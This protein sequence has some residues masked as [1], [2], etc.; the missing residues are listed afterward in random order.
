[1]GDEIN[2]AAPS[3][4]GGPATLPSGTR[5]TVI[6]DSSWSGPWQVEFEGEIDGLGSP[7]DH[8][9]AR[10]GEMEYWVKFDEPQY[11]SDG[12]GPYRKALIWGRYLEPISR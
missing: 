7:V 12:D 11:D 2:I 6:Q 5:V 4:A 10:T 9:M 3:G 8:A 1:M